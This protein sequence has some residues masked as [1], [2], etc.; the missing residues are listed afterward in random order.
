M[1]FVVLPDSPAAGAVAGRLRAARRIDH[2]SGRPWIVGDWPGDAVTVVTAGSRRMA[3]LGHTRLDEAAA[4]ARLGRL[5][6]LHDADAIASRLPGILHMAVSLDGRTRVQGSITGVRQVFTA[7][8]DGVTVAASGV[9]PLLRLTGAALDES[10]LAARLLAPGG[11]PWPVAQR[12]VRQGIEA[13]T[14][15]CWLELDADGRSRQHHWWELPKASLTLAEG[16][17]A[18]RSALDEAIAIRSTPRRTLSADLSGGLDSTSLCFLAGATG[19]DLVT[20][21]VSPLDIANADTFWARRAAE[22]L[23]AA[24][25]HLLPADRGENL[26]DV[27]YTDDLR[28]AAPEGPSTW[29]SGLAHLQDLAGRA[30]AEGAALHLTGFG[31]DELF[32]RMPACAWSLARATP[33]RGLRLVNRYRLANRW[34]WRTTVRAL[35]DRSTF[36][37]NLAGAAAAIGEPPPPIDEPDFGWVFAPRMPAWATPDAVAAVR[38]LLTSA[39]AD[40]PGPLDADRARHQA[41]ASLVF[42]GTTVRQVNTA[43]A[44]TGVT[45]DAPFLDD[46]VVE[47]ALAT[48]I[49]ERLAAGRFKPLLAEAVRGAVPAEILARRDK[50]EFSAEAFRGLARNRTRILELCEDSRL[51][52][53]G[54]VDPRAFRAAV[55]NPGPMSHHLQ[56]IETTVACESWLRTHHRSHPSYTGEL[57]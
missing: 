42:E 10:V 44:G 53:L 50:G 31:G 24:R 51:A 9:E 32:G 26:F 49:D 17:I 3:L 15:G 43:L 18:V 35:L 7:R 33:V 34:P 30:A 41:L 47:A 36:R 29:A 16:A 38:E 25:H 4:V 40:G 45:W 14:T 52:A 8:A 19:A 5:R 13:L 48:R 11:A 37:Q 1:D 39:A 22:H 54:L 46:R 21:H 55:L 6:S 57:L 20:Y 12:P 2:V 28:N 56:P 27:G 23:P